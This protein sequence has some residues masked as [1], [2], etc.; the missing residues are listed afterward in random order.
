M[1]SRTCYLL[2]A[3]LAGAG[4]WIAAEPAAIAGSCH[5]HSHS[6]DQCAWHTRSRSQSGGSVSCDAA[7]NTPGVHSHA[8]ANADCFLFFCNKVG[9]G[10]AWWQNGC[11]PKHYWWHWNVSTGRFMVLGDEPAAEMEVVIPVKAPPQSIPRPNG[12]RPPKDAIAQQGMTASGDAIVKME[13]EIGIATEGGRVIPVLQGSATLGGPK[14]RAPGFRAEGALGEL[15]GRV[16]E[17]E[18]NRASVGRD[19]VS[20]RV[21]VPTNQ[22]VEF[23][24]KLRAD[25]GGDDPEEAT[26][27]DFSPPEGKMVASAAS[28]GATLRLADQ[29]G[30]FVLKSLDDEEEDSMGIREQ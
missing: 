23:V 21:K 14:S 16:S 12:E 4:L 2:V 19:Y 9:G 26:H 28:L 5:A 18:V 15:L 29:S 22:E 13:V 8:F 30:R 25:V 6:H 20:E 17:G 7:T 27:R 10:H 1:T 24:F 11:G 3:L